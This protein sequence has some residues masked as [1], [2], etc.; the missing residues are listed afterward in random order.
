MR[1]SLGVVFAKLPF[2]CLPDQ[3]HD[4]RQIGFILQAYFHTAIAP[5]A[6]VCHIH[7][8]LAR[9]VDLVE[10]H[11]ERQAQPLACGTTSTKLVSALYATYSFRNSSFTHSSNARTCAEVVE[12]CAN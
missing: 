6:K 4:V 7:T 8:Q 12:Q 1:F 2:Q 10:R 5:A 9:V 3:T 11:V